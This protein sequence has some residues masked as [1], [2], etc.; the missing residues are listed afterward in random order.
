[1]VSIWTGFK[2]RR[3][4]EG[5]AHTRWLRILSR[6]TWIMSNVAMDPTEYTSM[7]PWIPMKCFEFRMLYSSCPA[8]STISVR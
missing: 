8:V 6:M 2:W 1:M 7:Y 5:V 4:L 3:A